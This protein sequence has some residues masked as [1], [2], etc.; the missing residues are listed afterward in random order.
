M[1]R[2]QCDFSGGKKDFE[3]WEF[4]SFVFE[5]LAQRTITALIER[6]VR[7]Q[8]QKLQHAKVDRPTVPHYVTCLAV[9]A[10]WKKKREKKKHVTFSFIR[11]KSS[12]FFSI[13]P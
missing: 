2:K 9:S 12:R 4:L 7:A 1:R 5:V 8:L 6:K 13:L 10:V 3:P 11:D